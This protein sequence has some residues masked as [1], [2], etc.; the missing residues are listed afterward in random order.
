MPDTDHL[1]HLCERLA[2]RIRAEFVTFEGH[3]VRVDAGDAGMIYVA[4]RDAKREV[5]L[6]EELSSQLE[7]LLERELDDEPEQLDFA[8]SLGST[9]K[10][11][12]LQIE[13]RE[14]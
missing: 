8:I 6:G 14:V 4:I 13:V 7:S 3:T 2:A 10:D 9:N 11:L 12:L 1:Q 5:E